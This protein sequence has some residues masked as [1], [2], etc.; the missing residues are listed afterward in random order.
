MSGLDK[1]PVIAVVDDEREVS[2]TLSALLAEGGF[3]PTACSSISDFLALGDPPPI[4]LA[5]IDL[6]LRG[7]SGLDLAIH[8]RERSQ[9]PIVMLTGVGD[10][11]D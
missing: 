8:I 4:D 1:R 3:S 6:K 5:L 11:I 10:E 9:L 7:E 2:D